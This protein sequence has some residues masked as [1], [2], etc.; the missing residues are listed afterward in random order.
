MKVEG[1]SW[2]KIADLLAKY[3]WDSSQ[4]EKLSHERVQ[5]ILGIIAEYK[6][7]NAFRLRRLYVRSLKLWFHDHCVAIEFCGPYDTSFFES[8]RQMIQDKTSRSLSYIT[9]EDPLLL[10][11]FRV[12][13][14]DNVWSRSVRDNLDTF[15]HA[16]RLKK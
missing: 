4:P 13:Y 8:L 12:H 1:R 3:S 11:G 10:A 15:R 14:G 9:H 2:H 16:I 6:A 5:I 7:R